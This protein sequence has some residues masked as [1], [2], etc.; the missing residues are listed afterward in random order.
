MPASPRRRGLGRVPIALVDHRERVRGQRV[1]GREHRHAGGRG[2]GKAV[3]RLPVQRAR[4]A[5]SATRPDSSIR[6]SRTP[7]HPGPA[8]SSAA[9]TARRRAVL[10]LSCSRPPGWGRRGVSGGMSGA[11]MAASPAG[12]SRAACSS[13]AWLERSWFGCPRGDLNPETRE[14]SPDR[15]NHAI[16]PMGRTCPDT[17]RRVRYPAPLSG[18]CRAAG[19]TAPAAVGCGGGYADRP[20][21]SPASDAMKEQA[22]APGG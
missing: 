8:T 15:G 6:P 21:R 7:R 10:G 11:V 9:A 17:L 4:H 22:S 12:S 16:T 14:I 13:G 19:V 3:P 2:Q 5:R 20:A 1:T 18:L